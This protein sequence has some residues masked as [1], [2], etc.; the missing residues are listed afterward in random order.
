MAKINRGPR[1]NGFGKKGKIERRK[2]VRRVR[3]TEIDPADAE[4]LI[5]AAAYA[6][7]LGLPLNRAITLAFKA[8][9]CPY[10]TQ[11]ALGLFLKLACDWLRTKGVRAAFI[12]VIENPSHA[13]EHVHL[14]IH[15]PKYLCRD[16]SRLQRR[17]I[18]KTKTYFGKGVVRTQAFDESVPE[19]SKRLRYLLKGTDG[20]TRQMLGIDHPGNQGCVEGKRSGISQ[21]L[22]PTARYRAGGVQGHAERPLK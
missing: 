8:N 6:R 14:L 2:A 16:F 13:D 1:L 3:T 5:L 19:M 10:H 15:V 11:V 22:G 21:S 4:S 17:W 9:N 20:E 12:W 7:A 18:G